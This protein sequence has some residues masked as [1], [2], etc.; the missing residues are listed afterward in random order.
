MFKI[1][2]QRAL[3]CEVQA[4]NEIIATDSYRARREGTIPGKIN[5]EFPGADSGLG[6][7]GRSRIN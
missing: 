7:V 6:R 3:A 5:R 4:D 2:E 1:A